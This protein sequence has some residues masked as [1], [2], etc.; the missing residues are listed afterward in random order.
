MQTYMIT[1]RYISA[2]ALNVGGYA[3]PFVVTPPIVS[4]TNGTLP[5]CKITIVGQEIRFVPITVEVAS[6]TNGNEINES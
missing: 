3:W 4:F 6:L 1:E 5:G 2:R